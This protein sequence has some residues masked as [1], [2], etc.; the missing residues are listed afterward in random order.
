M[1]ICELAEK[2]K[3]FV[4]LVSILEQLELILY[5]IDYILFGFL[6]VELILPSKLILQV[7]NYSL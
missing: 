2:Q 6:K 7:I 4:R 3:N 5:I 1:L